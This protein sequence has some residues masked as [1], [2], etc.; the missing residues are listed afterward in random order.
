MANNYDFL[1]VRVDNTTMDETVSGIAQ[2]IQDNKPYN[3]VTVNPELVMIARSHKEFNRIVKDANSVTPDGVGLLIMGKLTGR[4]LQERV[5]GVDLCD[6]L[7]KKASE[8]GWKIYLLGAGPG[9]AQQAAD[10][11]KKKY[12]KLKIVGASSADPDDESANT[13]RNNII[14]AKP[15]ILLVAYGSPTQELWIDKHRR[16]FDP[17]VTIGVGGS[18]DFIAGSTKRAPK[19][20]QKIG[21]EWLWR[22]IMQPKRFKRMLVLPKFAILSLFK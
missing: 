16:A 11:L 21:L 5:T 12:P 9:I 15:N 13:I 18:F 19:W 22:L 7:A 3:V 6:Q 14:S 17:L 4:P 2:A 10:S 8:N 20:V 1:G